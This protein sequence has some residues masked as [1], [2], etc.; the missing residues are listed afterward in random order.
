MT[1][2]A[3]SGATEH[4]I[5]K[6]SY[7]SDFAKCRYGVIKSTNRNEKA[8]MPILGKGRYLKSNKGNVIELSN[9]LAAKDVVKDLIFLKKFVDMDSTIPLDDK[10]NQNIRQGT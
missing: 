4:I 7:L 3:D 1:F 10:K 8:D 6:G 2:I 9:V 5:A